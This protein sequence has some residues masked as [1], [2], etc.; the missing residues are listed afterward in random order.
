MILIIHGEDNT[1]SRNL[2]FE[3]KNKVKNPI[4]INGDGLTYDFL[5]N[6]IENT[7][8]FA[9]EIY[10]FIE[11]FFS[12]NKAGSEE[13]KKISDYLNSKKDV[14]IVFWD[15]EEISKT[16]LNSFK[17]AVVKSFTLPKNL[18]PFLDNIRPNNSSFLINSFNDL[19]KT[20]EAEIILFMIIRQ[21][22]LLIGLLESNSNS[23]EEVNRLQSW[24]ASKLKSQ[25]SKFSHEQLLHT[26][27]KL[28][29]LDLNQKTGKSSTNLSSAI[30]FFLINL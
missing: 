2:F 28:F 9:G 16:S 5:F 8:L 15:K 25:L 1:N 14:N 13:F 19:L 17:S 21:F 4:L 3:E 23:I 29:E 10:F 26:Y 27:F 22:R 20:T 6:S 24:Q 18:F 30:D 11:N 7:S 12:K